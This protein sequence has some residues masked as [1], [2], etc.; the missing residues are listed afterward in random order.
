MAQQY[1]QQNGKN[2]AD[3]ER[4]TVR[5][6]ATTDGLPGDDEWLSQNC[7]SSDAEQRQWW[8]F[9]WMFGCNVLLLRFG[10][11]LLGYGSVLSF[12]FCKCS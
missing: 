2:E 9:T 12:E 3:I 7:A 5:D 6:G 11:C 8:I 1:Y 10:L 4:E